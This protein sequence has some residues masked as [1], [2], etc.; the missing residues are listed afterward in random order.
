M[1]ALER[2]EQ[3]RMKQTELSKTIKADLCCLMTWVLGSRFIYT[4]V[5]QSL[6]NRFYNARERGG[7]A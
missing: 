1:A 2:E 5:G 4:V 7:F 6:G 3:G